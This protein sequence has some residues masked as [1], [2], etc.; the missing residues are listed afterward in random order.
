MAH[1]IPKQTLTEGMAANPLDKQVSDE[2]DVT[3]LAQEGILTAIAP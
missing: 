2:Q 1:F 3:K